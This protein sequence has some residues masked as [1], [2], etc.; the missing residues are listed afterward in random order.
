[1]KKRH[2]TLDMAAKDGFVIRRLIPRRSSIKLFTLIELLVV[3]AIIAILAGMLLPALNRAK[4]TAN[5]I[6]CLNQQKQI[7]L[8]FISYA[9]DFKSWS[10][11]GS[12]LSG[13]LYKSGAGYVHFTRFLGK[14]TPSGDYRD[15]YLGYINEIYGRYKG[16][17]VCPSGYKKFGT[18]TIC[19]YACHNFTWHSVARYKEFFRVDT[20]KKPSQCAWLGDSFGAEDYFV[21]CHTRNTAINFV[22]V[23]G[24]AETI[25]R[26][27]IP[28]A[29]Y[30]GTSAVG[31]SAVG[32]G[33]HPF[34]INGNQNIYPFKTN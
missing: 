12:G 32:Q 1:M 29:D 3:I 22:F 34:Q 28:I 17:F 24:H 30:S 9:N 26:K 2:Q 13:L 31:L 27:S 19:N 21:S 25:Q 4:Q 23:D 33:L 11:G 6:S 7:I 10:I 16:I 20:V 18:G 5:T 15:C 14:G 8:G